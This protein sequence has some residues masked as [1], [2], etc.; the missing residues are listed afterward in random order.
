MCAFGEA[1][2]LGFLKAFPSDLVVGW[3]SGTGMAGVLGAGTY[4]LLRGLANLSITN[5]LLVLLPLQAVYYFSF[6][7]LNSRMM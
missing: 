6:Y 2:V 5:T 3:S 4:L 7:W 1:V